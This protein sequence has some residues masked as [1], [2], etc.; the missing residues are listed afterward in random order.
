MDEP[1]QQ[2]LPDQ[3]PGCRFC[4]LPESWRI[5]YSGQNFNIQMGLGP[6]AEGYALVLTKSHYS[7]C[8]AIP[9]N[10]GREFAEMVRLVRQTQIGLYGSSLMFEHGRSGACLPP[11]HGEDLCYHAHLHMLPVDA[12]LASIISASFVTT[13]YGD[14]EALRARYLKF[15]LPYLLSQDGNEIIYAETPERIT[16]RYLRKAL[17]QLL[18]QPEFEDWVA[19]PRYDLVE[20]GR[21]KMAAEIGRGCDQIS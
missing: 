15:S 19:F 5:I 6:L 9:E 12:D 2:I 21:V 4:E 18:G 10:Q 16:P 17:A 14:W 11:E 20:A 1:K 8:A 3:Q 13:R 7:C